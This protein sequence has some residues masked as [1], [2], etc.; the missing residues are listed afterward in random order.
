M[1]PASARTPKRGSQRS[2]ARSRPMLKRLNW[3]PSVC[4]SDVGLPLVAPVLMRRPALRLSLALASTPSRA[5]S[6]RRWRSFWVLSRS[7]AQAGE[8]VCAR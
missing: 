6:V 5:R 7:G 4:D 2:Q 3:L 8:S 1:R